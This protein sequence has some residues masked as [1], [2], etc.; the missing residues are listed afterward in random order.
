LR[1]NSDALIDRA[2][3]LD[4]GSIGKVS[5]LADH[6][7]FVHN[8]NDYSRERDAEGQRVASEEVEGHACPAAAS[9][10]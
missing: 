1:I 8:Q 5:R 3:L 2:G 9:R 4:F 6:G 7:N 10:Y